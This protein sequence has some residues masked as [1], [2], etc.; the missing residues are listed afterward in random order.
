[1][2]HAFFSTRVTRKQLTKAVNHFEICPNFRLPKSFG[3]SPATTSAASSFGFFMESGYS[4]KGVDT[5]DSDTLSL[6]CT[7]NERTTWQPLSSEGELLE[8]MARVLYDTRIP[9]L[10]S[11]RVDS[12]V[13]AVPT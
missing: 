2:Q 3:P 6:I 5:G 7:K 13:T 4:P 11:K 9:K 8:A 10:Q 1:M 12:S